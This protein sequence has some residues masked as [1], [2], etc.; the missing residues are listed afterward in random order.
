MN[1]KNRKRRFLFITAEFLYQSILLGKLNSA[2]DNYK[3]RERSQNDPG[4]KNDDDNLDN[5][6]SE[7]S[8]P[9]ESSSVS[10]S[11]F[12]NTIIA[13]HE[14]NPS[15]SLKNYSQNKLTT[16]HSKVRLNP[17]AKPKYAFLYYKQVQII[18]IIACGICQSYLFIFSYMLAAP[19]NNSYCFDHFSNQFR[20]CTTEDTCTSVN[21][22]I[23]NSK[24]YHKD[25]IT[26]LNIING[27]Y[28]IFYLREQ[29]N[30]IYFNGKMNKMDG[31]AKHFLVKIVLTKGEKFL[32]RNVYY[33]GCGDSEMEVTL[34]VIIALAIFFGNI[35]FVYIADVVGR[36]KTLIALL[37]VQC[38]SGML[39]VSITHIIKSKSGLKEFKHE[40]YPQIKNFLETKDFENINGIIDTRLYSHYI[41]DYD[42]IQG[43]YLVMK[44]IRRRFTKS[45]IWL[46]FLFF[47]LASSASSSISIGKAYLLEHSL[48]EDF[49]SVD[50]YR[51]HLSHP[52]SYFIV[53]ILLSFVND[54][55]ILTSIL[56]FLSLAIAIIIKCLLFDSIRYNYEFSQYNH[57]THII[58]KIFQKDEIK[59]DPNSNP[60]FCDIEKK[61]KNEYH[62]MVA[63]SKFNFY[64]EF[65]RK[66]GSYEFPEERAKG[67]LFLKSRLVHNP[68]FLIKLIPKNKKFKSNFFIT[69]AFIFFTSFIYEIITSYTL[70]ELFY[71]R[72]N[73]HNNY[74]VNQKTFYLPVIEVISIFIFSFLLK[75]LDVF[76]LSAI[77]LLASLFLSFIY[78]IL[79]VS[80]VSV[81]DISKYPYYS[82][83]PKLEKDGGKLTAVYFIIYFFA[84]SLK[85]TTFYYITKLTKTIYRCTFY[86][87]VNA[88]GGLAFF[89]AWE[90]NQYFFKNFFYSA[91]FITAALI[92][93]LFVANVGESQ[94]I[95]DIHEIDTKE[96]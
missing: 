37:I 78:E 44:R 15:E 89:Y 70:S 82:N 21:V 51:I 80:Y 60:L 67:K 73:L 26:E 35:F 85:F 18:M 31:V 13:E 69:M 72:K 8:S 62:H 17:F 61:N 47:V 46:Y 2:E 84:I 16:N 52:G 36:R 68:T 39:I 4:E 12:S 77:T 87:I 57:M 49:A 14:D 41:R 45:A 7:P 71:T 29:L 27:K 94:L 64:Y 93:L 42:E 23:Y 91:L 53:F 6:E 33:L 34:A 1:K 56:S 65:F 92:N 32:F 30:F 90:I 79:S 83:I 48:N 19:R 11:Q 3:T 74:L 63:N 54:F 59:I 86:G 20:I 5:F 55:A 43:E 24:L 95:T 50:F 10:S 9:K 96:K 22:I 66:N 58:T 75:F 81:S 38:I 40:D 88:I 25:I 76:Y 28:T